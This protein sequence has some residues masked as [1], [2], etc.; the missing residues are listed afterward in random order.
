MVVDGLPLIQ[1]RSW[2]D[3]VHIRLVNNYYFL[4][5]S[6]WL[7]WFSHWCTGHDCYR[8]TIVYYFWP[9]KTDIYHITTV[10]AKCGR[11]GHVTNM[12]QRKQYYILIKMTTLLWITG[13]HCILGT[14][15]EVQAFGSSWIFL[16]GFEDVGKWVA[17]LDNVLYI[18]KITIHTDIFFPIP[19]LSCEILGLYSGF[20]SNKEHQSNAGSSLTLMI[21]RVK[22]FI[23]SSFWEGDPIN[24]I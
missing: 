6:C 18:H 4:F 11:D 1:S 21:I 2:H 23:S 8:N 19:S 17:V 3:G 15:E 12:W 13:F 10:N 22:T 14:Y 9:H 5:K 16:I 20:S 24:T 7:D